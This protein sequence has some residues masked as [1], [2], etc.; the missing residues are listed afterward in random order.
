MKP[1]LIAKEIGVLLS[2]FILSWFTIYKITASRNLFNPI[3][4]INFHDTYFVIHGLSLAVPLFL[5]IIT[6][7]YLIREAFFLYRRRLQNLILLFSTFLLNLYLLR[8]IQFFSAF[9]A[10]QTLGW[11]IYPPLS[12]LPKAHP[13]PSQSENIFNV[14]TYIPIP[15]MLI[16]VIVAILVG[17]NWKYGDEKTQ[18]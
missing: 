4:D 1:K 5:I 16:L 13:R 9:L 2:I 15:F 12:T 6:S 7:L 8:L 18:L 10:T 11:S 14:L 17:K 3:L